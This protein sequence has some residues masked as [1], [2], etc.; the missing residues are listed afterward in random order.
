VGKVARYDKLE[1][2]RWPVLFS[3]PS[4][5][6][7]GHFHQKLAALKPSIPV[8]TIARDRLDGANPAEAVWQ[9]HRAASPLLRLAELPVRSRSTWKR[10][11]ARHAGSTRCRAATRAERFRRGPVRFENLTR[12]SPMRLCRYR[13]GLPKSAKTLSLSRL[14]TDGAVAHPGVGIRTTPRRPDHDID[15]AVGLTF[16]RDGA[17]IRPS[18]PPS[19]QP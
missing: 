5:V 12:P 1:E 9:L 8:A 2:G 7:E 10:S 14:P 13:R 19:R 16:A 6:R 15:I 11:T 18:A 4:M 3:L 17:E